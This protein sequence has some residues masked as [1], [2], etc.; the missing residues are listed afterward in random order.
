MF[1]QHIRQFERAEPVRPLD[2][3]LA[4]RPRRDG[5]PGATLV[6]TATGWRRADSLRPGDRVATWDGGLRELQALNS[7]RM[8]PGEVLL[9]VPGGALDNCGEVW[10]H[11]AQLV[12]IRSPFAA[13]ILD[14]EA[15]LLPA[16]ALAGFRGISLA[17]PPKALNLVSL[18]FDADELIFAASGLRLH[19][20]P[21]NGAPLTDTLGYLPV[22][23]AERGRDL[24][25]LIGA[26]AMTTADLARA[27]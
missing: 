7:G 11:E 22:L 27:A 4:R 13:A 1:M 9:R 12:L 6:E 15:V 19:A 5:I 24:V 16:R 14:A 25:A 17:M 8:E 3:L 23:N 26:D 20:A 21:E 18:H 10:L 2:T